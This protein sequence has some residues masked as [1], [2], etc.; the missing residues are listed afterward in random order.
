M[1]VGKCGKT[2]QV[3]VRCRVS[4]GRGVGGVEE[5]VGFSHTS[6]HLSTSQHTFP[7]NFHAHSIH[8]ATAPF[9]L[10]HIPDTSPSPQHTAPF[11]SHISFLLSYPLI[12]DPTTQTTKN[13]PIAPSCVLHHIL[14]TS[15][16]SSD[17]F[18]YS[19]PIRT[20]SLILYQN[21]SLCSFIAKFSLAIKYTRNS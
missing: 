3:S 7:H 9:I 19:P 17:F 18:P 21:F 4:V 10:T 13:S 5:C 2:C 16:F 8:S 11:L 1:S 20:L 6:S 14:Y 15:P 12:L